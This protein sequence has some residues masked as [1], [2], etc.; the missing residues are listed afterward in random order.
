M[1]LVLFAIVACWGLFFNELRGEWAINAQ[2]NYGYVVPLLGLALLWRR[3]PERPAASSRGGL[4]PGL[5][6]A[7][8]IFLV[9]PFQVVFEAN[10]EWRLLYWVNG[11]QVSGLVFACSI[12][13]AAGVG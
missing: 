8:L 11:L 6:G 13:S 2:Y 7:G 10:P 1:G 3:W 5:I 4:L 9:L 12:V